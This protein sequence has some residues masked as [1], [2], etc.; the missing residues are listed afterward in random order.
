MDNAIRYGVA[1][2][3]SVADPNSIE[4][5]LHDFEM[6]ATMSQK[7]ADVLRDRLDSSARVERNHVQASI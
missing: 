5:S 2:I 3:Q 6:L 7:L 1:Q 4:D